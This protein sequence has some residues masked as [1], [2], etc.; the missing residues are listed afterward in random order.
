[1]SKR[2]NRDERKLKRLRKSLRKG[3]LPMRINLI[4]FLQQRGTADTAGQARKII[5]EER[6]MSESHVL[7]IIKINDL[8]IVEPYV[9]SSLRGTIEIRSKKES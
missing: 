3:Q 6:V 2:N 5:E 8:A 4:D 1:M 7:G 9:N